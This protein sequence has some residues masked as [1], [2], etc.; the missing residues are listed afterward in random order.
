MN[1]SGLSNKL[2]SKAF[3]K[4]ASFRRS[5]DGV[6]ALEFAIIAPLLIL[7]FIGTIEVSQAV[8]VDRKVSR[9]SS[10]VADQVTQMPDEVTAAWLDAMFEVSSHVMFPHENDIQI[11]VSG[12]QVTSGQAKVVWS[13]AFGQGATKLATGATYTVPSDITTN[14]DFLVAAKVTKA[15]KPMVSFMSYADGQ[16]VTDGTAI[17]LSEEMFLRPRRA[18]AQTCNGC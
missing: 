1:I 8:S 15:H 7:L 14:D 10:I 9:V 13:R 3:C 12:L 18:T 2:I 16:L 6:A 17:N 5:E 11:V 4:L